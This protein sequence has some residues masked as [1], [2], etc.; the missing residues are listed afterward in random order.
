M[1]KYLSILILLSLAPFSW[2]EYKETFD[3]DSADWIYGYGPNYI[4]GTT[5][6][7]STGGNP[8]GYISGVASNLY[9]VWIYDPAAYGDMT[10]LFLT[11]DTKINNTV[12]GNAQ[13]YVGRDGSYYISDAWSISSNTTW[14]TH[15][16]ALTTNNFSAWDSSTVKSLTNV[17]E[18]P[19][20]IGIFFGAKLAGGDGTLSVD[21][22][23]TSTVPEPL[24]ISFIGGLGLFFIIFRRIFIRFNLG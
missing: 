6:W 12:T 1:K 5:E 18:A 3:T 17:L 10:G 13:L 15:T 9:A 23:G 8:D 2:A 21:N 16:E 20:D 14:T 24:V 19:D 22:F 11:I 4:E 7:S